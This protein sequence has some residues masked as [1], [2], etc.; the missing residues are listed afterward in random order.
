[1]SK[2]NT[3]PQAGEGGMDW[4]KFDA[5]TDEQVAEAVARDPDAVPSTP[6]QLAR[7][8]RISP[9]RYTRQKLAMSPRKFAETYGIPLETQQK[10]ERHEAEPTVVE[11]AYLRAIERNPEI[12]RLEIERNVPA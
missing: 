6:E 4:A 3:S 2:P 5:L 7:M 8:R 1:M 12:A 11:L 9:A 10:W